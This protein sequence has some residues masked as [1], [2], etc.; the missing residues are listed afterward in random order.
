MDG[1]DNH[2]SLMK[3]LIDR[4]ENDE[5]PFYEQQASW[6]YR[7]WHAASIVAIGISLA[8]A[9]TAELIDGKQFEAFGKVVL[10]VLPILAT[11]LAALS[12][13]FRF[14]EKEA[15][16]EAGRIEI[17]DIIRNAKNLA[18]TAVDD[19]Q[20]ARAYES[21]RQ[22]AYEL[23]LK[24]HTNDVALRSRDGSGVETTL[25]PPSNRV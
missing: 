25:G 11:G 15:L 1:F 19:V 20:L 9:V 14:D 18:A 6:N 22:R 13:H 8:T 7:M 16:R 4:L 23:E 17:E 2:P 21:I 10:T 3:E 24:Q 5:R 12:S